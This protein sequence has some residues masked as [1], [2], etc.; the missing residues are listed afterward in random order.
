MGVHRAIMA[1]LGEVTWQDAHQLISAWTPLLN[2]HPSW[3]GEAHSWEGQ[4][5]ATHPPAQKDA[6]ALYFNELANQA[7]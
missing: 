3:K 5:V 6:R 7:S 2:E 1:A 4:G